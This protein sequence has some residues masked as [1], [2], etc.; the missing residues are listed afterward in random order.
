MA[1]VRRREDRRAAGR[2]RSRRRALGVARRP[3]PRPAL[4]GVPPLCSRRRGRWAALAA[5]RADRPRGALA[6]ARPSLGALPRARARRGVRSVRSRV[7]DRQRGP[8]GA[9]PEHD[10]GGR[11]PRLHRGDRPD[12]RPGGS[13]RA[14]RGHG[15]PACAVH[16][17]GD[18]RSFQ[19]ADGP[20]TPR[21]LH[22]AAR[23]R[24][25]ALRMVGG[26]DTPPRHRAAPLRGAT[27]ALARGVARRDCQRGRRRHHDISK[28]CRRADARLSR[29]RGRGAA[30]AQS[31]PLAEGR[32]RPALRAVLGDDQPGHQAS[33][34]GDH[35]ASPRRAPRH[36]GRERRA[37]LRGRRGS[38]AQ[39]QSCATSRHESAPRPNGLL[40]KGSSRPRSGW[41]PSAGWPAALR[42][43]ST[44]C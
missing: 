18:P 7:A 13:P 37:A 5:L 20:R 10:R 2:P 22:D 17:R 43:T 40:C 31:A 16:A 35:A 21:S 24:G 44:T 27:L 36:H 26:A 39:W 14:H 6:V 29:Q 1:V 8:L 15:R 19:R 3:H 38:S 33:F 30:L 42:T 28:P 41:K 25:D 12:A 9:R 32:C 34:R 4:R 23:A 11:I